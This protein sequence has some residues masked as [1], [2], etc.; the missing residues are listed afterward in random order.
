M[1]DKGKMQTLYPNESASKNEHILHVNFLLSSGQSIGFASRP[2]IPR[3]PDSDAGSAGRSRLP[4]LAPQF[5]NSGPQ[6]SNSRPGSAG[7]PAGGP[8]N[9]VSI[10][11]IN[12]PKHSNFVCFSHLWNWT[13]IK[14]M[15]ILSF[16]IN[17]KFLVDG[18]QFNGKLTYV[19]M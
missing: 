1:T 11:S 19:H 9:K 17:A 16:W 2:K 18:W 12:P 6:Q 7:A 13:P 5:S 14:P 8:A 4:A 10:I 15:F 3:T